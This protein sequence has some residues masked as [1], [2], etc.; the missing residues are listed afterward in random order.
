M[1]ATEGTAANERADAIIEFAQSNLVGHAGP[2]QTNLLCDLRMG[3]TEALL[4][5]TES[6]P[7]LYGVKIFPLHVLDDCPLGRRSV[8]DLPNHRRHTGEPSNC[9]GSPSPF[10]S[11]KFVQSVRTP[12]T[13]NDRLHD[14][15]G[16]NR[17]RER[18]Q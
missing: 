4:E 1:S 10:T 16:T 9:G 3:E 11:H 8:V 2:R 15:S 7:P 18:L 17:C 14:S 12:G 13:H 6:I 5:L